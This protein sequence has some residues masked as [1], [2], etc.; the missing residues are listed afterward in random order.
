MRIRD[1]SS[2]VCSSDLGALSVPEGRVALTW[3]VEPGSGE[4]LL[5]WEERGGPAVTAPTRRGFGSAIIQ[6]SIERQLGG[7]VHLH[8]QHDGLVCEISLPARQLVPLSS[9]DAVP[10]PLPDIAP[11]TRSPRVLVAIGRAACRER[12]CQY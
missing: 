1:W 11:P 8:W 3:S 9:L 12:G 2:D 6:A 5:C 7:R 10:P 4:L